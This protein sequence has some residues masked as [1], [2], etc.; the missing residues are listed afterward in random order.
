METTSGR[1]VPL[2][3]RAG[4]IAAVGITVLVAVAATPS[5]AQAA[6]ISQQWG[7]SGDVPF[8]G[9]FTPGAATADLAVYR[10][11]TGQ[12]SILQR[13]GGR[14]VFTL[15]GALPAG[16][17]W[18][19]VVADFDGDGVSDVGVYHRRFS[20]AAAA[21]WRVRLSSTGAIVDTTALD[22]SGTPVPADYDGDGRAEIAVYNAG[23]WSWR[24]LFTGTTGGDLW[25]VAGD[26]PVPA[27]WNGNAPTTLV[28][29][30]VWRP[31]T[32]EWF[33]KDA[34]TGATRVAS[35]WGGPGDVPVVA[36][37]SCLTLATPAIY[38]PSTSTFWI[39][40]TGAPTYT[41]LVVGFGATGDVP[42]VG[43]V[44]GD[45]RPDIT[46]WRPATGMWSAQDVA[47]WSP[48]L[49]PCS[50]DGIN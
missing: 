42:V 5:A 24:N 19:P 7:T 3:R 4:R 33:V 15:G 47:T 29:R 49:L 30:A 8:T 9:N 37:W 2:H 38:R 27:R 11:S 25:G 17:S 21:R 32:G 12:F 13:N 41:S 31:S 28:D 16:Q 40:T 34:R 35:R 18:T 45:L 20:K 39:T 43:D 50:Y 14:P 23:A 48:S 10:P 44:V 26:V 1:P 46:V 22:V 6:S 36:A